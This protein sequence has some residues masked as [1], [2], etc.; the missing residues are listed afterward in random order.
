MTTFA[1]IAAY[2]RSPAVEKLDSIAALRAAIENPAG[3]EA[4]SRR[5]RPQADIAG[6]ES[7][8]AYRTL[9]GCQTTRELHPGQAAA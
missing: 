3:F 9:E 4:I 6:N 5:L 8:S 7:R 2:C 1:S